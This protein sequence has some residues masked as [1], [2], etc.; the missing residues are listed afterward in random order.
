MEYIG[1]LE[2][3]RTQL[4]I[5]HLKGTAEL[6]ESFAAKFGKEQWGYCCGLLHD[7]GKYS[8]EF[9]KRI[10]GESNAEVDHS[11]AG[12]QIGRASCRE[13]V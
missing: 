12:A 7:I 13:R 4:L 11:T 6:C 5:E 2:G 8:S 10:R 1:H 3:E 9:Q